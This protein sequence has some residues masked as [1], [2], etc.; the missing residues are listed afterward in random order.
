MDY[1]LLILGF[2]LLVLG[3]LGCIL[4]VIP[5]PPLSFLAL[6]IL[7]F[8]DWGN[9]SNTLLVVMAVLAIGVTVLDY[10]VPAWGT[11]KFGGSKRGTWGATIGVIVGLFFGPICIILFPFIGA[12]IGEYTG[13]NRTD[14]A[15]HAAFG[16]FIGI[17][18]GVVLKLIV[19]GV[20]TYYFITDIIG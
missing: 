7:Q 9:S 15:L 16:S 18:S 19:S 5:G 12:F 14:R 6:F 3:L 10:I 11:K 13:D 2:T 1:I 17:L 20:I 4:P 8:T